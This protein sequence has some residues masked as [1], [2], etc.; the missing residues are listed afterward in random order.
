MFFVHKSWLFF[1]KWWQGHHVSVIVE[2]KVVGFPVSIATVLHRW[3]LCVV[4]THIVLTVDRTIDPI[5]ADFWYMWRSVRRHKEIRRLLHLRCPFNNNV[6][7]SSITLILHNRRIVLLVIILGIALLDILMELGLLLW[8]LWEDLLG[9]SS[10]RHGELV[11]V[12]L[13]LVQWHVLLNELLHL[14]LYR[15][16]VILLCLIGHSKVL[17]VRIWILV[18]QKSVPKVGQ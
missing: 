13:F 17:I 15:I 14:D 16:F 1:I 10:L 8:L 2:I 18:N 5:I 4:L 3:E 12:R 9:V 11:L 6:L 7:I